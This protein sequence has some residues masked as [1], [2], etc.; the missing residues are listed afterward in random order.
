MGGGQVNERSPRARAHSSG[1][2]RGSAQAARTA[3]TATLVQRHQQHWPASKD[4]EP[5]ISRKKDASKT[6]S[7]CL[8]DQADRQLCGR[9]FYAEGPGK[10]GTTAHSP[11]SF[12]LS[13]SS[14]GELGISNIS[15]SAATSNVC[16][17][18]AER[19]EGVSDDIITSAPQLAAERDEPADE[20][21]QV[22]M[23]LLKKNSFTCMLV[24]ARQTGKRSIVKCFVKLLNE[25]KLA[26]D[27][28]R[29]EK[30]LTKLIDCSERLQALSSQR[31]EIRL[32]AMS[33]QQLDR[34]S[35]SY[36]QGGK[37]WQRARGN[38][39]LSGS[40]VDRWLRLP[41]IGAIGDSKRRLNS[42]VASRPQ[43]L[44]SGS[45]PNQQRRHT[46]IEHESLIQ[47]TQSP[48]KT[49]HDGFLRVDNVPNK[50]NSSCNKSDFNIDYQDNSRSRDSMELRLNVPSASRSSQEVDERRV[51]ARDLSGTFKPDTR[52]EVGAR[53]LMQF[54]SPSP[55]IADNNNHQMV[56][57]RSRI[58]SIQVNGRRKPI[59]SL[60]ELN[61][62]RVRIKF[63]TRRQLS[64]KI[65]R[66]IASE[67][68][69]SDKNNENVQPVSEKNNCLV[70]FDLPDSFMVVYS[71]NDR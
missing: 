65:T 58:Q 40:P 4:A 22:R 23:N 30:M 64:D 14:A 68:N 21:E 5:E 32:Q 57:P 18:G 53:R 39:W 67:Q 2:G 7:D 49:T 24:G 42:M 48:F 63:N 26:L 1:G 69:N 17:G 38:S 62:R 20:D 31:E 37:N 71:V 60:K 46:T 27:E 61:K 54:L 50:L 11:S 8:A 10:H 43:L 28:Y 70:E 56:S 36:E 13:K 6:C 19:V 3:V 66:L 9:N 15:R 41:N 45:D 29:K 52:S 34:R 44:I 33:D 47:H 16:L 12:G 59:L 25:F 51:S 35:S 55:P